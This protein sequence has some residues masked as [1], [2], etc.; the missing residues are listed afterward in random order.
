MPRATSLQYTCDIRVR[1]ATQ[2]ASKCQS[3]NIWGLPGGKKNVFDCRQG[4]SHLQ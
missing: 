1:A 4:K 3:N 2:A